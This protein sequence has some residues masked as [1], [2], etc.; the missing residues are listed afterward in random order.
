MIYNAANYVRIILDPLR[1]VRHLARG[2]IEAAPEE[3]RGRFDK[4]AEGQAAPETALV[5]RGTFRKML[6]KHFA[7]ASVSAENAIAHR[8]FQF[9]PRNIMCATVGKVAGLDLYAVA[10]K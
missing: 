7:T 6:L 4:N 2:G 9:V 5:S 10:T 1:T 3:I 8:P